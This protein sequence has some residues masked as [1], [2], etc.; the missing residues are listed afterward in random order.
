MNNLVLS[1]RNID[2]FILEVANE[3]VKRVNLNNSPFN[4]SQDF[5]SE[6]ET[7]VN[8]KE[9][10]L[11]LNVAPLTV[12]GYCKNNLI[13]YHKRLKKLYFFKSELIDWIKEGKN[14]TL[15]ELQKEA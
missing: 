6:E 14:K 15:K 7:P 11:I 13:P 5:N 9:A 2:D 8:L 4:D 12:R 10:A 3:V 1:T